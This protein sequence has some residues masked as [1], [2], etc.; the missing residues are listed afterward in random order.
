MS[1]VMNAH[2]L[3]LMC[4]GWNSAGVI[5]RSTSDLQ[6]DEMLIISTVFYT[7]S[8]FTVEMQTLR[9]PA[10]LVVKSR[11]AAVAQLDICPKLIR[12]QL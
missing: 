1:L 10:F 11:K 5:M 12:S 6:S 2:S 4:D 8:S 3:V 9:R 7:S